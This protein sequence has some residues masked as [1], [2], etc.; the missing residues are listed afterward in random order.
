MSDLIDVLI[1]YTERLADAGIKP[2]VGS[3]GD[4]YDCRSLKRSLASSKLR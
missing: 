3:V 1:K 2:S 4:S